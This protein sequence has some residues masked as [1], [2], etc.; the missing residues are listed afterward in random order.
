MRE[1]RAEEKAE[2]QKK[3]LEFEL[4][5]R[6]F[7]RRVR[8]ATRT[9]HGELIVRAETAEREHKAANQKRFVAERTAVALSAERL[10]LREEKSALAR[11]VQELTAAASAAEIKHAYQARHE[12]RTQVKELCGQIAETK[13]AAVEDMECAEVLA[14]AEVVRAE[15]E[16]E[17]KF[18]RRL[19]TAQEREHVATKA[20]EVASEEALELAGDLAEPEAE[21]K[22]SDADYLLHL[23]GKR[24]ARAKE[25]T[26]PLGARLEVVA[27]PTADRT[28]DE[29][30]LLSREARWK[31]HQREQERVDSFLSSHN[32][33]AED[34]AT[35]LDKRGMLLQI[36]DTRHAPHAT[37][38]PQ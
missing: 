11:Q 22:L 25:R 28:A 36:F 24:E 13:R 6:D 17:A 20:A 26:A 38:I 3:S 9:S 14:A 19:L 34:L 18:K 29:W 15:A 23:S 12:L 1:A 2:H 27:P 7:E 21:A 37:P 31:A 10:A 4:L 32:Y 30:A 16:A 8:E 35:V 33:C 5:K